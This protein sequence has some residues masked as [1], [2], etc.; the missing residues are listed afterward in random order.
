MTERPMQSE[1]SDVTVVIPA[2]GQSPHLRSVL[3]ALRR[4]TCTPDL[5]V[6]SHSADA[7]PTPWIES[8]FPE[9][10][11]LHS[12]T[13]LY[14]GAARN[15]GVAM[16]MTEFVAFC[17]CDVL[18]ADNWL[19]NLRMAICEGENRFVVGAVGIAETGGYWGT[20]NW[21]CE[22]SEQA[23]WRPAGEQNGGAS[24]NMMVR[25]SDFEKVGGFDGSQRIGE[26]TLL[27]RNL[28]NLGLKQ[29]LNPDAVVGHYNLTGIRLF[30]Q[31]QYNHGLYFSNVRKKVEMPGSALVRHP[32]LAALLFAPKAAVVL[33]RMAQD[34]GGRVARILRYG[35]GVLL[36]SLI[37]AAGAL[38][39]SIGK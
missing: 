18:P 9:V 25:R 31:H 11:I 6:V 35:P 30:S 5:I 7:D 12:P 32:P 4:Q 29:Y 38:R 20:T 8:E 21:H 15:R 22:F 16:A 2:Y 24:C 13:R 19:K 37:F 28:R 17:D 1:P 39:G 36:G 3:E 33:R 23:P 27:L 34:R 10:V 14:A 26:D